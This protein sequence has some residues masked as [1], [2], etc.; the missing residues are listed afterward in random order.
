M[1]GDAVPLRRCDA[2]VAD[3]IHG[4]LQRGSFQEQ[5]I[6]EHLQLG[7]LSAV[8]HPVFMT[9]QH[10]LGG[11][12]LLETLCSVFLF[13][14]AV[15][16]ASI[17]E[18]LSAEELDAFIAADLFRPYRAPAAAPDHLYSPVRLAPI[19]VPDLA[20]RDILVA[21]DR[22]DHPDGSPFTP[23]ADIVFPGHNPLTRR[24]LTLLPATRPVRVLELCA[25]SGIATL[26]MASAGSRCVAADIAER[27]VHFARFNAWLNDCSGLDV[28]CGD[29]Y[30]AV[31]D[32]FDCILA[33]PPYVPALEQRLTYR[34]GGQTGDEIIR[35]I[36]EGLPEHL[37][38]GG[39]CHLLCLGM[40]TEETRF[41]ERLRA[42][43]GPS[44]GEFDVIFALDSTTPP[45]QVAT[46][47]AE[48]FGRS[49]DNMHK[50][51][52]L[53]HRLK[54]KDFV[55]GSVVIRRLD[56][57]S[58][59]EPLTRRVLMTDGTTAASFMQL[60][61]WF[62]WLREPGGESRILDTKPTLP[63]DLRLDVQHRMEA[64]GF[65]PDVF[66]LENGG[67]PF[68]ARLKIEPWLA[69]VLVSL[70]GRR[71]VREVFTNAEANGKIPTGFSE[72]DQQRLMCYLAERNCVTF[73]GAPWS[74]IT[75]APA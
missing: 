19:R 52:E 12:G 13:G 30:A 15:P 63:A 14:D 18:Y 27:S 34:D 49:R 62:D 46:R 25:G 24:F 10:R 67:H 56:A 21:G 48:P 51:H 22:N 29:L 61:R 75:A 7:N 55:Y 53:F 54:V 11:S 36:V 2:G 37:N 44:G 4:V 71:T 64:G 73:V 5:V 47:V 41:E 9:L 40:D 68:R 45:E 69:S 16:H 35:R 72:R 38:A 6:C 50:W 32:G 70:D 28:A 66:Y 20:E 74:S 1:T 31:Q 26:A 33:H 59:G 65:T 58:R 43:L 39:T 57:A 17:R 3:A 8:D 23:F 42:W 60:L